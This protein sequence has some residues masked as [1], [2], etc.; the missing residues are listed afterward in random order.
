MSQL[1]FL[2][3]VIS[4]TPADLGGGFGV[5]SGPVVLQANHAVSDGCDNLAMANGKVCFASAREYPWHRRGVVVDAEF[6]SSA[7]MIEAASIGGHDVQMAQAHICVNGVWK[8]IPNKFGVYRGDNGAVFSTAVSDGYEVLQVEEVFG[9][10]DA[11]FGEFG[12]RWVTAGALG[13]GERFWGVAKLGGDVSVA[14]GDIVESYAFFGSSHDRSMG[15]ATIPTNVRVVCKNTFAGCL[16]DARARSVGR[17][18]RH[19]KNVRENIENARKSLRLAVQQT[20]RF[21]EVAQELASKPM[22]NGQAAEF[23][24]F[25]LDDIVSA[26]VAGQQVTG[27]NLSDRSIFDAALTITDL[28]ERAKAVKSLERLEAKRGSLL[29]QIIRIQQGPRCNG[30][31]GIANTYW[32]GVNAVSEL[33]EHGSD[34][35][36]K[37]AFRYNGTDQQRKENRMK[38]IFEGNVQRVVANAVNYAVNA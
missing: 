38:S 18:F 14:L 10:A 28:T 2:D 35:D 13:D 37:Q 16:R 26:T 23:Y 4:A 17:V 20:E 31:P 36:E 22:D 8:P 9:F 24:N 12:A 19:T 25:C 21:G 33:C 3:S 6:L 32:S 1:S 27:K 5:K 30:I 7:D 11:V 34:D 15:F 29:D